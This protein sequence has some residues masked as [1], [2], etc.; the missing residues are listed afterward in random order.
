MVS[1]GF[2]RRRELLWEGG[3]GGG[4]G[5]HT[6]QQVQLQFPN[7][8]LRSVTCSCRLAKLTV[9]HARCLELLCSW[10]PVSSFHK[11]YRT[12]TD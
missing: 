2:R 10:K 3:G 11:I 7:S 12:S 6:Q 9:A 4:G 1:V 8:Y 5:V